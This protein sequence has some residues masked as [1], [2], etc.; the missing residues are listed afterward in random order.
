MSL[1]TKELLLCY[2]MQKFLFEMQSC[3]INCNLINCAIQAKCQSIGRGLVSTISLVLS[4]S[5]FLLQ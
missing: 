1:I 2:E 3:I 4:F 5:P